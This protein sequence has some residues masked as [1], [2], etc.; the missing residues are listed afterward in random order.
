ME[1]GAKPDF[2]LATSDVG[3]R[4]VRTELASTPP[5]RGIPVRAASPA[6]ASAVEL[7]RTP[8]NEQPHMTVTPGSADRTIHQSGL[9]KPSLA[10]IEKA[11]RHRKSIPSTAL[12]IRLAGYVW[13]TGESVSPGSLAISTLVPQPPQGK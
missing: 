10:P 5:I 13:S 7:T 12:G 8:A 11:S 6:A 4:K 1:T 3:I 9:S 2:G